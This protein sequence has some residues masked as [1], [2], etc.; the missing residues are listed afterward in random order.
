MVNQILAHISN[1]PTELIEYCQH[2]NI[3]AEAYSPF[4]HVELSKN[5]EVKT[6]A[7]KYNVSISQLAIRYCLQL[8]LLSPPKTANPEHMKDNAAVDFV[9]TEADMAFLK[10]MDPIENYGAHSRFPVYEIKRN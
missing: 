5:E 1:T 10:D 9:F 4:G 6:M 8:H 7:N 3:L 2:E